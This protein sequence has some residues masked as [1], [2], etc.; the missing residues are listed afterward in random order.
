[1]I[2]TRVPRAAAFR[3][4]LDAELD[5]MRAFLAA[6]RVVAHIGAR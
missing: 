3:H 4:E 2:V 6:D 5:R 1:V